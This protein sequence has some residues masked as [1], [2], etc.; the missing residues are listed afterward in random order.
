MFDNIKLPVF[1]YIF[2]FCLTL[3][4]L[5]LNAQEGD[6]Q[7]PIDSAPMSNDK[8]QALIQKL[9]PEFVG[10]PGYWQLQMFEIGV[11]IITDEKA[12]RMRIVIPIKKVEDLSSEEMYRLLQANFDS[13]LDARYAVARGVVWATY[14]HPLSPLSDEQFISGLGQTIN[15]F[16]T[17]GKTYSSGVLTFGGGDSKELQEKELIEELMRR[18]EII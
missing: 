3:N 17:Y 6:K 1:Y 10:Q 8:L 14:I 13:A 2:L 7:S 11:N 12:D 5:V 9:D 15:I 4:S 18:G 16:L